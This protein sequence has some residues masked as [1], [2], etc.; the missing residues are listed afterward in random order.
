MVM[1]YNEALVMPSNYAV[2]DEEE[3]TYVEGGAAAVVYGTAKEIR[4]RLTTAIAASLT[5]TGAAAGLGAL[6]G[7]PAG[8]IVGAVL[9]NGWYG[10]YRSCASSAHNQVESIIKKYG[11]NKRCKMT[12]TTSIL[13]YCT[14]I[15]VKVA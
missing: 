14:G 3:M 6:L 1:T 8:A 13:Y 12:T 15:T 2:M 11:L 7:G 4:T 10:S 5:G 9:G